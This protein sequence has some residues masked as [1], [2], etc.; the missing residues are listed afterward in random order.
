MQV[1]LKPDTT[2]DHYR[3]VN[4]PVLSPS[5]STVTST[6]VEHRD[7]EIHERRVFRIPDV[8]AALQ[9]TAGVAGEDDRQ[10]ERRVAIAVAHAGAVD[11]QRVIEQRAVAVGG[12][13]H[14]LEQTRANSD[15][16]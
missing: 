9:L 11:E 2:Y 15:M 1:R 12:V 13:A 16:L 10:L 14:L 7:A 3:S 5:L 8:P 6:F 4:S